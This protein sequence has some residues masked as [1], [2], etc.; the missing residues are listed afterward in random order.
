MF[1]AG[2]HWSNTV[3]WQVT[4]LVCPLG[5][6]DGWCKQGN[7]TKRAPSYQRSS[8]FWQ[9]LQ[10]RSDIVVTSLLWS[11]IC[12]ELIGNMLN[13]MLRIPK[14]CLM[15]VLSRDN[16]VYRSNSFKFERRAPEEPKTA[17][18]PTAS[19]VP[20]VKRG[21]HAKKQVRVRISNVC[22]RNRQYTEQMA[23]SWPTKNG[24]LAIGAL[25]KLG[26]IDIVLVLSRTIHEKKV[27]FLSLRM[28][29]L[30][31]LRRYWHWHVFCIFD[32][33]QV[34]LPL[35]YPH[36]YIS[37]IPIE[38]LIFRVT[39]VRQLEVECDTGN[40]CLTLTTGSTSPL[41]AMIIFD[42]LDHLSNHHTDNH[43]AGW[44]TIDPSL[45]IYLS[46]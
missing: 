29:K 15:I 31:G 7:I 5:D 22:Q 43:T 41:I 20:P 26:P 24:R 21:T 38:N 17:I 25:F 23:K 42:H 32:I 13:I 6:I 10:G 1:F 16:A 37:G 33:F 46:D 12:A 9:I 28:P 44:K 18:V 11:M 8:T 39:L 40:W 36:F 19:R 3:T 34:H 35:I 30:K 27:I 14:T 2:M 45:S 4:G